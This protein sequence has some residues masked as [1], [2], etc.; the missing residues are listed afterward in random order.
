M[1][2]QFF[3]Q[4]SHQNRG[5]N[6]HNVGIPSTTGRAPPLQNQPW[7]MVKSRRAAK[8]ERRREA[9]VSID[10][11]NVWAVPIT[12]RIPG[13]ATKANH[14]PLGTRAAASDPCQ[15]LQR[16][17]QNSQ[18]RFNQAEGFK[19]PTGVG[20]I[21]LPHRRHN[22]KDIEPA[23]V[24]RNSLNHVSNATLKARRS[25]CALKPVTPN[26]DCIKI[27]TPSATLELRNYCEEHRLFA[28][29]GG[30]DQP[31]AE[32]A[33]W[34][35]ETFQGQ[36]SITALA[37]NFL[38]IECHK[39]TLKTKLLYEEHVFYNR[40]NF[41]FI[42]W[43]SKFD[44]NK[45]EFKS[46][47][48]WIEICNVPIELMHAKILI[49]I[50]DKLG[51]FIAVEANWSEK[52]DIKILIEVDN[53]MKNLKNI[54][55]DTVDDNYILSPVWYHGP[56]FENLSFCKRIN[57]SIQKPQVPKLDKHKETFNRVDIQFNNDIGGFVINADP[58][59]VYNHATPP[60]PSDLR[61]GNNPDKIEHNNESLEAC[62]VTL[63][64][65]RD[66]TLVL[67]DETVDGAGVVIA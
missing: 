14:I 3:G 23:S 41:N 39:K 46:A 22:L 51:K 38:Y 12:S 48:K 57:P 64:I 5:F 42:D 17:L 35:K 30:N 47:S 11:S 59:E 66:V 1:A 36:V 10:L 49:E 15:S 24:I 45:F 40:A 54:T 55:L 31:L 20:G 60:P 9:R 18:P 43:Q 58:Q 67:A 26:L 32:I 7:Q 56:I 34:W 16:P 27:S 63:G 61:A 44:A 62:I 65:V 13:C 19:K 6:N 4:S 50:G 21:T 33:K 37:N 8:A 53:G 28:K 29:W 25:K 52:S 2:L